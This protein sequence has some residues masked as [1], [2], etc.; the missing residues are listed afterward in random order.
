MEPEMFQKTVL[1]GVEALK[2]QLGENTDR[3]QKENKQAVE[4]LGKVRSEVTSIAEKM[5]A[6][7][8]AQIALQNEQRMAIADPR[9]R[10]LGNKEK[11]ERFNAFV[12]NAV[13]GV[14]SDAHKKALGEDSSPGSTLIDD[15]LAQDIYDTLAR[16]GK[17]GTLG[18]RNLGT[19]ITKFPVKT[20][21][22]VANF[23]LTEGGTIGDD[24]TKAGTSLSLEVEVIAALI[25]VSRQLI[26]DSDMDISA[27]VLDDFIE[28]FNLRLDY[29]SFA[30]DGTADATN[31][32][33]TGI[34]QGGTAAVA[35]STR[36]TVTA[37]KLADFIKCLTT[38]DAAVLTRA[39]KWWLHPQMLA[40]VM[41]I[42]DGNGRPLFQSA[43]E[44]PS[45][46]S[47]GSILGFPVE[48]VMTAPTTDAASAKVA[49]F[50]DP[51]G[52]VVGVRS[53]FAFEA[54]DEHK[55]NTLERS[56]RGWGRAGVKIRRAQAFAVLTTAA[57]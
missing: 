25:N 51:Q 48:L 32:G 35:A 6:I 26:D 31:G 40:R 38:V 9:Q 4:E 27:D 46:G 8:K 2:K 57:S 15:E 28:A 20:A 29:A 42:E 18:A 12:R 5:L 22:P 33:M 56:F 55:W 37:L 3:W 53:D 43:V 47:I 44:A 7:Q 13:K 45:M 17:W 19:K 24:A 54:S 36:T 41:G 52:C 21:R 10:I 49:V 50:G 30:A 34:F 23:I 1:D 11:R 14:L 39:A 16:Y